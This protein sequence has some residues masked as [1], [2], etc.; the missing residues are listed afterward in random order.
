MVPVSA[1]DW[2]GFIAF[3][4]SLFV[5]IGLAEQLRRYFG[6]PA[7]VTRKFVHIVTGLLIFFTPYFF[8]SSFPLIILA[9]VFTV[10]NYLG[11]RLEMFKGMHGT[12]RLTFGTVFYPIS[13]LI[14]ILFFWPAHKFI[15]QISILILA[16][17]D[18]L[19]AIVGENV[20]TPHRFYLSSEVKSLEG[21][22]AMA[23]A[24]FLIVFFGLQFFTGL[25]VII[26][27]W[28]ALI[29]GLI[30][31]AAEALSFSGSDNISSPLSAAFVLHFML[32]HGTP[33]NIRFSMGVS[34]AFLVAMI[35]VRLRFLQNS[36]A[37]AT[38][39]LGSLIFGVGGW[40][41]GIP[42]LV[43]FASSSILSKMWQNRKQQSNLLYEK[44]SRRDWAQVFANGSMPALAILL[45]YITNNHIWYFVYLG[46]LAAV[47]A[48][49]WATEIGALSP[50]VP[51]LITTFRPAVA[52]T[53]GAISPLGTLGSFLGSL[54]IAV[55]GF[56]F[57]PVVF[58]NPLQPVLLITIAG[59]AGGF[60]DSLI[61]ATVQAQFRCPVCHKVTEK[62][63]H[64]NDETTVFERGMD[65]INNDVVNFFCGL[66]GFI[67]VLIFYSL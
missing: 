45:F 60:I 16:V 29:T 26:L 63:R 23:G 58:Q 15:M 13:F 48:D 40:S 14:L 30:A 31:T 55:T 24:S 7:E 21:S 66:S 6:W 34:L 47:T 3:F 1:T 57:Y 39:L 37:V 36:G 64:C 54:L 52:G 9:V 8:V 38:F 65:F 22:L 59:L 12:R 46:G 4:V 56:L 67:L 20:E 18:A 61:G 2:F 44:S 33:E 49:T 62:R 41:W 5:L 10:I 42:I 17:A 50:S 35:S 27:V 53:S 43:F 19:A 32:T 11:L 25:N 51:R 28:I